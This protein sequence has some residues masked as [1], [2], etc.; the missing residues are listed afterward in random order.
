M[1]IKKEYNEKIIWLNFY[2]CA[3]VCGQPKPIECQKVLWAPVE[4]LTHF[5]FPPAN[6]LVIDKLKARFL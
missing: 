4:N 5:K 3:Y 2:L 1:E 6:E